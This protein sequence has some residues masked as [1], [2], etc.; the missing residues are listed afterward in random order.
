MINH[1]RHQNYKS[2]HLKNRRKIRVL[3]VRISPSEL[4][5]YFHL[6]KVSR[7]DMVKL[8]QKENARKR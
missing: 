3:K 6:I 7:D 4:Q 8:E 1:L 5:K 2:K